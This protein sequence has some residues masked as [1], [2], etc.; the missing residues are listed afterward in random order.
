M[1]RLLLI[2]FLLPASVLAGGVGDGAGGAGRLVQDWEELIARDQRFE[3]DL[4]WPV[5]DGYP[6]NTLCY[7]GERLRTA[8]AVEVCTQWKDATLRGN[9]YDGI[10][11][12]CVSKE[13][14][15]VELNAPAASTLEYRV[16]VFG[17]A[18]PRHERP[19][20]GYKEYPVPPCEN[21]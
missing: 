7:N 1:I 20:I 10:R 11:T 6:V 14:R 19:W 15:V 12:E 21:P 5:A 2:S 18:N 13:V 4:R 9:R 8:E 3:I 16:E 17:R